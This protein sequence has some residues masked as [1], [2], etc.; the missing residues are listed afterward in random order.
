M[1]HTREI[2]ITLSP[3]HRIT[4]PISR[5][6]HRLANV[7]DDHVLD[8]QPLIETCQKYDVRHSYSILRPTSVRDQHDKNNHLEGGRRFGY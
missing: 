1:L 8:T 5:G 2:N 4:P 6:T 7:H 3:P